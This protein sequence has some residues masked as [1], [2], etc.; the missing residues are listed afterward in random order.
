M[1]LSEIK[2]AYGQHDPGQ[3]GPS[4]DQEVETAAAYSNVQ[5]MPGMTYRQIINAIESSQFSLTPNMG[6]PASSP[7]LQGIK[8]R[9]NAYDSMDDIFKDG[10]SVYDRFVK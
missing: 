2:E 8:D 4:L 1:I 6:A 10:Q 7:R 9:L 3:S 5:I